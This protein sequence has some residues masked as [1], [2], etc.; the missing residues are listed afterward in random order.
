M[1]NV[2]FNTVPIQ[3]R[4]WGPA[5]GVEAAI[6]SAQQEKAQQHALEQMF[7]ANQ[8][9]QAELSRYQQ[10]T[11]SEVDV[12]N[13]KG[14]QSRAQMPYVQD[15]AL[16]QRGDDQW[17]A[18]RGR[19]AQ[20]TVGTR[21]GSTNMAGTV[22]ALEDAARYLEINAASSGMFGQAE[23]QRFR[24]ALPE[25]ARQAF[26]DMYTPEIPG[27]IKALSQVLMNS[28]EHQRAM[29]LDAQKNE[30]AAA[31]NR[32]TNDTRYDIALLRLNEAWARMGGA[33]AREKVESVITQYLRKKMDGQPTT[34]QED[35]AFQWAQQIQINVR[36]AA[37]WPMDPQMMNWQ[38][39][40]PGVPPP[41]RPVPQP[42][43][44]P[45][46]QPGQPQ[47][48]QGQPGTLGNPIKLR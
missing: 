10:L 4:P 3:G 23:Y 34:P 8:Q 30:A 13:L 2:P 18:A 45:P 27:K 37:G 21:I 29:A 44:P 12:G 42:V 32:E 33:S 43:V 40:N 11:P 36:A 22:K 39:M 20:E 19:E 28:P 26:P 7:I 16:G 38:M 6:M 1:S 17:R 31:R 5:A 35:Q 14:A 25:Q 47:P 9:K 41:Q 24:E 15:Y 48:G 46:S